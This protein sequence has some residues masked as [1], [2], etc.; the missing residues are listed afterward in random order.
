MRMYVQNRRKGGEEFRLQWIAEREAS[1]P[2][3]NVLFVVLPASSRDR[4]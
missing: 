4:P 1:P 2:P 3:C